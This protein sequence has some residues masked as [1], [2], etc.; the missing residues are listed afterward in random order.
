MSLG[1][2]VL[3][4]VLLI[5]F[6]I[7]SFL[8]LTNKDTIERVFSPE[9][10]E[11]IKVKDQYLSSRAR[12]MLFLGSIFFMIL[13]MS[14]PYIKRGEKSIEIAGLNIL[15]AIDISGSMR[16]KDVY[17]N[18]FEFAKAKLKYLFKQMPNDEIMLI[19]F[20]KDVYLISPFT[21]DKEVLTTV[22]EGLSLKSVQGPSNFD[23]LAKSA[24]DILEDKNQKIMLIVSDGGDDI[25]NLK[26]FEKVI[27]QNNITLYAILIGTKEGG[28]LFDNAGKPII[29]NSVVQR[30]KLNTK[31]GEIAKKSGGDFIIATYNNNQL[32]K[33]LDKIYTKFNALDS[34]KRVKIYDRVE[35]F[36]YP[37]ILS[38]ILLLSAFISIPKVDKFK[39]D[40]E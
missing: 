22:I 12:K 37:L 6:L 32:D 28:I 19:A 21:D 13:A 35:L 40:I 17:P 23:I 31:L 4:I 7:F 34:G 3:F 8:L 27:M 2:G 39:K 38:V 11:R 36:I 14:H 29:L 5:P 16:V 18:R 15:T 20:N 33:L 1:N 30:S 24:K 10:L 26:E 9:V 25:A